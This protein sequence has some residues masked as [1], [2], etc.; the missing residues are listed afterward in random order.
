MKKKSYISIFFTAIVIYVVTFSIVYLVTPNFNRRRPPIRERLCKSNIKVILDAVEMYNI[1]SSTKMDD[2]NI[3]NL[4]KGHY[5]KEKPVPP[6]NSC[7]YFSIGELS[8]NG[9]IY[10]QFHKDKGYRSAKEID[11]E[12]KKENEERRWKAI[13]DDIKNYFLRAIPSIIYLFFALM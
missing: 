12:F 4:M 9:R 10:C 1:D 7:N 8:E 3:D 13:K 5:L 11:E 2:L 6:E